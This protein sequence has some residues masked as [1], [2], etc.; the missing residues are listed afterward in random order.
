V[1]DIIPE[2]YH[3]DV[4]YKTALKLFPKVKNFL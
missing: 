4:F 3:E 2:E 1:K